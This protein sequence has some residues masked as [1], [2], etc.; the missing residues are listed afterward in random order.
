MHGI[1]MNLS[2]NLEKIY[3]NC[4]FIIENNDKVG[5]TGV[6]GA[7][8]T[9][10]FQVILGKQFLDSGHI[11]IGKKRIGYL[12]QEIVFDDNNITVLDYL[13]SARPIAKLEEQITL[14]YQNIASISN[15]QEQNKILKKIGKLQEQLEYY[16]C[17]QAE[18]ILFDLIENMQIDPDILNHKVSELSGGQK[19]KIAFAHLLYSKNEILLLDEPTNHLDVET[20]AFVISYLQKYKGMVLIISHDIPFLDSITNKTLYIDKANHSI[21]VYDGNYTVFLKK[22]EKQKELRERIIEKQEKENQK[23]REI[24]LLYSNSSGKRKRMAQS[25]EKMLAK[26]LKKT[27][28]REDSNKQIHFQLKPTQES[29]KIP[30]KVNNITF[31]YDNNVLLR[32]LSF[33]ITRKERFLIIGENGVGKSTLLKLLMSIIEPK[34]GK[35][36]WDSKTDVAYYA[37][38]Q[39]ELDLEKSVFANVDE[40]MMSEKEIRSMLANFLFQ[41]DEVYKKV[42]YLS[43]G[44]RAR[45]CLCKIMMKKANFLLLDEPTNHLDPKTQ[46]IIGQ[47]F[48]NYEGTLILV[49][50]NPMFVSQIGIDRMLILP[51]GKI[52]NYSEEL[53]QY[54]YQVNTSD[55]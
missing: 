10:L 25:R 6:N 3:E 15:T 16:D 33:T 50:H 44:E 40:G 14:L 17:Y 22:Y 1:D 20:R 9:T 18:N 12:P 21:T 32:N 2:F 42:K 39:E 24:V 13:F 34:E 36:W 53:M 4:N 48:K 29:G 7:G 51:E 23:L 35:I 30:L 54:Y 41:G 19:S 47:N 5:I 52:Q 43:P 26:N 38:E 45:L 46:E 28:N 8:K 55:K 37:Q 49:S 11:E 27:L 31:G